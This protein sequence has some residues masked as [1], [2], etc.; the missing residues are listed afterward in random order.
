MQTS[1]QQD[2][3]QADRLYDQAKRILGISDSF[4]G[5]QDYTATSGYAKQ[6]QVQQS[7]GRA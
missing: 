1:I 4:Q 6:I 3:M 2:V 5:Q 7:Q